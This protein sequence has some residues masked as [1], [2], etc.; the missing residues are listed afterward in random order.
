MGSWIILADLFLTA[1]VRDYN[2][3]NW[4]QGDKLLER[5]TGI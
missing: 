5:K 2:E 1:S 3:L 4:Q